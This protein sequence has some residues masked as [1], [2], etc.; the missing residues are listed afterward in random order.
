MNSSRGRRASCRLYSARLA[1][2]EGVRTPATD[3]EDVS[4]FI[5]T[6]RCRRPGA[7]R[8]SII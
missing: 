2:L 8:S 4:P 1:G 7:S 3:F 6:V 5:Y